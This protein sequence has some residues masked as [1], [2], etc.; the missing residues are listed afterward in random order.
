MEAWTQEKRK[1]PAK[2][3]EVRR[4]GTMTCVIEGRSTVADT[5]TEKGGGI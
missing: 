5:D 3:K 2:H 4:R 1:R